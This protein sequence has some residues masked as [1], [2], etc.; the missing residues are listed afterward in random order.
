MRVAFIEH[1][2]EQLQPEQALAHDFCDHFVQKMHKNILHKK[3]DEDVYQSYF[4]ILQQQYTRQELRFI[5]HLLKVQA[6]EIIR[7]K[8]MFIT[9]SGVI[10]SMFTLLATTMNSKL[11]I[12]MSLVQIVALAVL[13]FNV[14]IIWISFKIE[15]EHKRVQAVIALLD[16]YVTIVS[17]G[18]DLRAKD[19]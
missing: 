16:Y 19:S 11:M 1:K 8:P 9:M 18:S 7:M 3:L 2:E 5:V 17:E 12:G 13:S 6:N 15:I 10:L 14:A 4:V